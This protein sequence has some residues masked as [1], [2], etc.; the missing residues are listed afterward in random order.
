MIFSLYKQF[1]H[2]VR[3]ITIAG[4]SVHFSGCYESQQTTDPVVEDFPIAYVKRPVPVDSQNNT[5]QIDIHDLDNFSEGGDLY[6]KGRASGGSIERNITADLTNGLGDVK[7]LESSYDGT[8]LIFAMRQPEEEDGNTEPTWNIWEYTVVTKELRRIISSDITADSGHDVAPH[9]LPDGRIV[10]SS[11]RQRQTGAMLLDEGKPKYAALNEDRNGPAFVLHVMNADG[12]DIHQISFNQS[13]DMDPTVNSNGEIVFSR[14]DN[15]ANR[16]ALNLYKMR[17]DGTE[18]QLLYGAHSHNTGTDN[19]TIQFLQPREMPNGQLVATIKRFR[20]NDGGGN[21]ITIDVDNYIDNDFPTNTT[22]PTPESTAQSALVTEEII[23]NAISPNG[24]Y[25]SAY[26]LW[27]GTRRLLVSWTPCRL[28]EDDEVVTCSEER[29]AQDSPQTA[30]PLYGIYIFNIDNNTH[31]P[32]T[33]PQEGVIIDEVITIQ[34]RT[35]PA[36]LFDKQVDLDLDSTLVNAGLGTLHIRSVYDMDGADTA[37]PDIR[38]IADPGAT[39]TD[40]RPARFLRIVKGVP[41]P[42]NDVMRVPGTAFGR[43]GG[44]LMR[45]IIGYTPIEP[46]G[47][48][49]LRVPA[50]VPLMISVLD[51]NGRRISQRHNNWLQVKPGERK[52]CNGCHSHNS[53]IPHGRSEGPPSVYSGAETSGQP[54]PNTDT[55]ITANMGETMA[56]TRARINCGTKCSSLLPSVNIVYE[57]VWT[58]TNLRAKDPGFSYLYADLTT[59]APTTASC[60]TTWTSLCRIIINYESHIHPLWAENRQVLDINSNVTADNTC[61]TCHNVVDDMGDPQVPAAQLDLSDGRDIDTP[62]HLKSYRELLFND[63]EQELDIDGNLNDRLVQDT[64]EQ[65]IPLVETDQNG[66]S[67][68]VMVTVRAQGPSMSVNSASTGYFL[69]KFDTGG[70]HAGWLSDAEKRLISEWLDIG[71]QYYNNPFDIQQ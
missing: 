27:D 68:P 44:Q 12:T 16:S 28:I 6:V 30:A 69:E 22:I 55:A 56:E 62:D 32:L 13:H 10:F 23:T 35:S 57:D 65:G 38:T 70:T 64:D 60:Q 3:L 66:D 58:D 11:T 7:D 34:K 9:Y 36:I 20:G 53:G 40:D 21:I 19:S 46:D 47:S 29:L 63:N 39:S 1:Q 41:T 5:R 42:P 17:P 59:Q 4:A 50:N 26:P 43:S 52:D 45:E 8:K 48:V 67:Q 24:H 15:V 18:L 2:I 25:R 61:T 49:I 33:T 14:W 31:I 51:K 71:G 37:T 54:F